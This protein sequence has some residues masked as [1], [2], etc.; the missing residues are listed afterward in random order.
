[1]KKYLLLVATS[2][3]F[4]TNTYAQNV[5]FNTTGALPHASAMLDVSNPNKG[6]LLPRVALTA[7]TDV[8]TIASPATSLLIYNTATAADVTPGY[9]YWN[10]TAWL[11]F[12]TV[13][14]APTLAYA[15]FFALMPFHNAATVAPGTP[16]QFPQNGPSNGM[17]MRPSASA[18][19]LPAVGTYEVH[20]QVSVMESGQLMLVLNGVELPETA[21]GRANGA[22]QISGSCFIT[23]NF[24]NSIL[25]LNNPMGNSSAL[26][27]TPLAGGS[28]PVSAHLVIKQ[29]N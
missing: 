2:F 10:G 23:T 21:V 14:T 29:L 25:S 17:I 5:G 7:S 27:I 13:A 1:M 22:S 6:L 24:V 8:A 12:S 28:Q 20:F 3:M 26:S 9:Y 19:I 11:K 18:F 4:L 15:D 16:V